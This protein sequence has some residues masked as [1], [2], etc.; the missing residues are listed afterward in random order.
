MNE[1]QWKKNMHAIQRTGSRNAIA[2]GRMEAHKQLTIML[3]TAPRQ[4]NKLRNCSHSKNCKTFDFRGWI[5]GSAMKKWRFCAICHVRVQMPGYRRS[6][7][8]PFIGAICRSLPFFQ[9]KWSTLNF[10]PF[11]TVFSVAFLCTL[12]PRSTPLSAAFCPR[13]GHTVCHMQC[14]ANCNCNPLHAHLFH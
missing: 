12:V 7:R 8:L 13:S 10:C 14:H 1:S 2:D 4:P 9:L 11:S 3:T 5:R 6:R